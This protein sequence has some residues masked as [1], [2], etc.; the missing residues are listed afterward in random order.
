MI[1]NLLTLLIYSLWYNWMI[2]LL[3]I[4][5][6][7]YLLGKRDRN[8]PTGSRTRI[9]APLPLPHS[10]PWPP[11]GQPRCQHAGTRLVGWYKWNGS[12]SRGRTRRL[13]H[14]WYEY[15]LKSNQ[16]HINIWSFKNEYRNNTQYFLHKYYHPNT[17]PIGFPTYCLVVTI[18]LNVSRITELM[19]QWRR[20][21]DESMWT[22]ETLTK[23]FSLKNMSSMT[24]KTW[25]SHEVYFLP[26]NTAHVVP[27]CLNFFKQ[28]LNGNNCQT[29]YCNSL[30][31]SEFFNG[32]R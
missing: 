16:D 26:V 6:I 31:S 17:L 27:S 21:T 23:V 22:C 11:D 28:K 32:L 4:K 25:R 7:N 8:Q 19:D 1:C 20:N 24:Q 18:T 9:F 2:E 29:C 13:A 3:L 5:I 14:L 15:S 10:R 12:S 30:L